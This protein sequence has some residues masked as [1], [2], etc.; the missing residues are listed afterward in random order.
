[1]YKFFLLT[2]LVTNFIFAQNSIKDEKIQ[3]LAKNLEIKNDII[4]AS[5]EVVAYSANYYITANRLI[6]DKINQK[7]ELFD[8]VNI[9]Q[10]N[11][12]V[13]YS[14]YIFIDVEKDIT[15]FKPMFMLD[16]SNKI[17][18]NAKNGL[19]NKDYIDLK[20]STLSS[21]D[22]KNPA[23]RINFSSGDFNTTEQW[24]NTYNTTLYL[25][26]IPIFYTPYFGFPTDETRRTGLLNPT[27][28]YSD[29]EGIIYAQPIYFAPTLNYDFEYIPQIRYN[30]GHGHTLNYRYTDSLY[31]NLSVEAGIFYEKNEYFREED[32]TNDKHYGFDLEYKRSKLFSH[33][34]SSDGLLLKYFDINDVD[35]FGTQ[36]NSQSST[37][38]Y[39]E[40]KFKYF[41]N[42]NDLYADVEINIYN[43]LSADN[44]DAVLQKLPEVNLH[45]YSSGLL[46]DNLTTS[47]NISSS[48]ETR[49]VGV[50]A[51]TTNF[52]IPIGYHQYLFDEFLNFSFVEDITYTNIAYTNSNHYTDV[53]YGEN[54]HIF[55]LYSNLIKPYEKYIH[56]T[57]V[58]ITYTDTNQFEKLDDMYDTSNS[59]TSDLSSFAIGQTKKNISVS[60]DQSF[61]NKTT[62]KEIVNHKIN[63]SY[64]DTTNS[65]EKNKLEN[66]LTYHYDYGS[67]SNRLI[68]DYRAKKM[69]TSSTTLKFL[70]DQYFV[71]MYYTNIIVTVPD[72]F[73]IKDEEKN[74]NLNLGF[75]FAK[76]YKI[77][78][79]ENYDLISHVSE[80]KEYIFDINEKC[81]GINFK[82]IDSIVATDTTTNDD[83]YR[84]KILYLE[85]NLKQLFLFNQEYKL[86]KRE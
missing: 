3:I 44:N 50:G 32:L 26:D 10:N 33:N 56:T 40:S 43:D 81:W 80:S 27:I 8:D 61:Y 37:S 11:K 7:L 70:K 45:K 60:L 9:I 24:I 84:Q 68:Y 12:I 77:S 30:R 51:N 39:L 75:S 38:S 64:D 36:Y 58:D 13:S 72:T 4:Y 71:N 57:N 85:F 18:F 82:V 48:R 22:C 20:N 2:I 46:N 15:S 54:N 55:S 76:Y 52:Y 79:K 29:S 16:N 73:K 31:S 62:L 69:T 67:L 49:I 28:G 17:W 35:Y 14:Q 1:M 23:W 6:Y 53:N 74:L 65:Y 78:Y 63:L 5:G 47:L 34:D 59:N 21:C 66:D 83:S 19:K 42:T 86:K 41:Y 25:Q